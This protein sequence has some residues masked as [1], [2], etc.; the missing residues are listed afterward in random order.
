MGVIFKPRDAPFVG[1]AKGCTGG[2]PVCLSRVRTRAGPIN[3]WQL[4]AVVPALM[5]GDDGADERGDARQREEEDGEF[6]VRGQLDAVEDAEPWKLEGPRV[7]DARELGQGR[8]WTAFISVFSTTALVGLIALLVGWTPVAA[9]AGVIW[10]QEG[11]VLIYLRWRRRADRDS[12][13]RYR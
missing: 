4:A 7:D 5:S 3:S 6:E 12:R 2:I 8:R 1:I 9:V 13:Y 10:L 11:Q